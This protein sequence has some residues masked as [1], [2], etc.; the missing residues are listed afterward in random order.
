MKNKT[1][2][3]IGEEVQMGLLTLVCVEDHDSEEC[4]E[5]ALAE[6]NESETVDC[7]RCIG[8]CEWRYRADGKNVVFKLKEE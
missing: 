7:S 3:A 6:L 8:E 4:K 2:F 5:C 1:E